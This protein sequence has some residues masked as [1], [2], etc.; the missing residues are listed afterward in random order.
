MLKFEILINFL[1]LLIFKNELFS[2]ELRLGEVFFQLGEGLEIRVESGSF[3]ERRLR[4]AAVTWRR[5]QVLID[6]VMR[7]KLVYHHFYCNM[8]R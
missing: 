2:F 1:K 3:V 8:V 6:I 7:T 5:E 4:V